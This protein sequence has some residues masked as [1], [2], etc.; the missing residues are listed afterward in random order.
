MQGV[1][2]CIGVCGVL[3]GCLVEEGDIVACV[4]LVERP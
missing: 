2:R 1:C 3:V 4:K